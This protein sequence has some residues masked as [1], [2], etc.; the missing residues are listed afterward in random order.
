MDLYSGI[1]SS[2]RT[3]DISAVIEDVAATASSRLATPWTLVTVR[4]PDGTQGRGICHNGLSLGRA[5]TVASLVGCDA[6]GAAESLL[7]CA[8]GPF[9]RSLAAATLNAL[10]APLFSDPSLPGRLGVRCS[11]LL[12]EPWDPAAFVPEKGR[13]AF[14]GYPPWEVAVVREASARVTVIEDA[15]RGDFSVLDTRGTAPDVA[16]VG[17]GEREAVLAEADTLFI[18]GDAAVHQD[19]RNILR[20]AP[21]ARHKVLFGPSTSVFPGPLF[22]MGVTDLMAMTFPTTEDF[23]TEF[24]QSRG[25]WYGLPGV[26]AYLFSRTP[27]A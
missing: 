5:E 18:L 24:L 6:L 16:V 19:L 20:A 1:I 10:S 7:T 12:T 17:V 22:D 14:V 13:V 4:F 3:A 15:P 23:R 9:S 21:R 8:A 27:K 25:Y 11:D 26:R 2:L